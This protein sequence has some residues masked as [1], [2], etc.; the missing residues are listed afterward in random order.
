MYDNDSDRRHAP[1]TM[2]DERSRLYQV[3]M[4]YGIHNH[5]LCHKLF[6]QTIIC[7]LN[8]EEKKL[9][10]DTTLNMVPSKNILKMLKQKIPQNVSNIK[11]IYNIC[12]INNKTIRGQRTETQQL[13]KLLDD[14][15]C[16]SMYKV[17]ED[18]VTARDIFCTLHDFIKLF[19]AFSTMLIIDST[20]KANMYILPLPQIVG[21]TS[22]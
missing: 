11:Q 7:L 2:R 13:L 9:I 20:Y 12:A 10:S 22:I 4:V 17:C 1:V 5:Y 18:E 21:V 16:A 6:G 14:K 8:L 15:H 19:N 3:I